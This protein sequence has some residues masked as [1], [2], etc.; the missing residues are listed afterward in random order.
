MKFTIYQ[1][2]RQGARPHNQDRVAYSYSRDALL[3]V[4][5]DGMS[6]HPHGEIAAQLAIEVLTESFQRMALPVLARPSTFL[7]AHIQLAHDAINRH[8]L[9][10]V[11]PE[12]PRTT[13][14]AAMVQ[15]D[16]LYC[17]HVG[18]SRLYHFRNGRLLFRT[19]DHSKVQLLFRM[20]LIRKEQMPTHPDRGIIYNCVGGEE[21]PQVDLARKRPLQEGDVVLLCT[22]G[23]WALLEEDEMAEILQNGAVTDTVPVLFELAESRADEHG[24]NMSAVAFNWGTQ[25]YSRSSIST[26]SLP[27]DGNATIIERGIPDDG[28][29]GRRD[30]ATVAAPSDADIENAI[31]EIHAALAKIPK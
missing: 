30:T 17:A 6:G 24:D 22:D 8:A 23:L 21:P 12:A 3:T 9:L 15:H 31:A 5:A 28:A 14:V 11:M 4:L 1:T 20:G 18:D 29:P 2:S 13:I 7:S 16:T 10:H 25:A 19:E 27:L 26:A